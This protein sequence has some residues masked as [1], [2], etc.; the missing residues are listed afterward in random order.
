MIEGVTRRESKR[1]WV[2]HTHDCCKVTAA[3]RSRHTPLTPDDTRTHLIKYMAA[4]AGTQVGPHLSH[5]RQAAE[6]PVDTREVFDLAL[7]DPLAGRGITPTPDPEVGSVD[8]FESQS[9]MLPAFLV[10]EPSI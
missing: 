9:V 10:R 3:R 1:D 4:D 2:P 7:C 6:A 5:L 8:Q